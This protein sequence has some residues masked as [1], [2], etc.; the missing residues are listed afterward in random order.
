M[1]YN[2]L[3]QVV[4]TAHHFGGKTNRQRENIHMM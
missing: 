1:I 4:E 3:Y 2:Y